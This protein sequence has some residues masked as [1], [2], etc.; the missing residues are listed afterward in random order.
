MVVSFHLV[1]GFFHIIFLYVSQNVK[2]LLNPH[3][4][5]VRRHF[6]YTHT[7]QNTNISFYLF[8]QRREHIAKEY[9]Q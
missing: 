3:I 9:I 8:T 5:L 2:K 7:I 1:F 4:Y 6:T